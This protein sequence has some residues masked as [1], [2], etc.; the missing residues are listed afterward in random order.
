MTAMFD[1]QAMHVA[2]VIDEVKRRGKQVAEVTADAEERWVAEIVSLAGM[3]AAAFLEQCTP[4]YYNREGKGVQGNMQN[5]AYAPGINA[6][7][8]LLAQWREQGDMEGM[9]LR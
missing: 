6:F 5:S 1:D 2:Y 3:G 7:N 4:G 9:E 8:A